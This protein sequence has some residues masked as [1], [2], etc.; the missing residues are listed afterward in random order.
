VAFGASFLIGS[1]STYSFSRLRDPRKG[2][3]VPASGSL[4]LAGVLRDLRCQPAFVSLCLVSG[5]WNFG[6]NLAG[7]FFNPRMVQDLGFTAT[8]VGLTAIMSTVSS[9]LVQRWSGRLSDRIGPRQLQLLCML[10]IPLLPF[11]WIFITKLWQVLLLNS[12]GGALWGAYSLVSFNLLLT[13]TPD[14]QR[15]RY[16]AVFQIL[17]TVS[18]ALGAAAGSVMIGR[19]GYQGVFLGS[20]LIRLLAAVLFILFVPG[21]TVMNGFTGMASR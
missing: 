1:L 5:L 20:A 18:L 10:F 17:V 16:S 13:L 21:R 12:V 19:W 14:A 11:A 7:P 2:R 3:P 15:A 6:V 8:M 4:S 9:L